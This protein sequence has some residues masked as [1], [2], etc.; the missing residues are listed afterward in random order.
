MKKWIFLAVG[1]LLTGFLFI[2]LMNIDSMMTTRQKILKTFYPAF[3]FLNKL[4]G[5][6]TKVMQAPASA[7]P[8]ESVYSLKLQLISGETKTLEAYKGRKLLL[9]NTASDCGYT[10][11]YDDLQSLYELMGDKLMIIGFPANDFKEQEKGS[12]EDIAAFCKKNYGVSFPLAAK[13]SV[14]KGPEQN[15]IFAWLSDKH[16]NGW[17]SKA[18]VW[19][20]SKYLIDENGK[21]L[22]YFDPSVSPMGEEM[23]KALGQKRS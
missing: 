6:N 15:E 22:F 17:N 2:E 13:S 1:V 9:V 19:N 23:M 3:S 10:P 21:L 4:T 12:N 8:H 16:K 5:S 20:F 14:I 11:Q 7:S 18:P